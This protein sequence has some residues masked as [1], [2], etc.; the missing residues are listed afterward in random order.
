MGDDWPVI[1]AGIS[2]PGPDHQGTGTPGHG[3]PRVI[4]TLGGEGAARVVSRF[5]LAVKALARL[6][7]GRTRV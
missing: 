4:Q 3:H 2:G 5:G 6:V 1:E 7:S